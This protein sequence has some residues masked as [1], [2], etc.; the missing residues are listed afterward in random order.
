VTAASSNQVVVEPFLYNGTLY[1]GVQ[2]GFFSGFPTSVPT[3][4]LQ[5][6]PFHKAIVQAWKPVM[7][8]SFRLPAAHVQQH[9]A[10]NS[11]AH[12]LLQ[13]LSD[14]SSSCMLRVAA[15]W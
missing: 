11:A 14:S 8:M 15:G 6:L 13:A 4:F 2:T 7:L 1:P 9:L 12:A 3:E 10:S 5:S